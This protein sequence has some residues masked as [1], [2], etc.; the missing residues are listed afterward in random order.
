VVAHRTSSAQ[1]RRT[2]RMAAAG[3]GDL[4]RSTVG[5]G[6]LSAHSLSDGPQVQA[7]RGMDGSAGR[8]DS[9]SP[10]AQLQETR[11]EWLLV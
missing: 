4:G 11:L 8:V 2:C 10:A 5:S 6:A 1:L 3:C 9:G 7:D